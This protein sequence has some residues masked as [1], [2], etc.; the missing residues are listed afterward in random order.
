[1]P[2]A[3]WRVHP[4]TEDQLPDPFIE[5]LEGPGQSPAYRGVAYVV[6]EDLP[7]DS[8]GNRLPQLSFEVIRPSPDP[9]SM[10]QLVRAVN[11]IPAAGEFIY[12]TETVTRTGAAP[13]AWEEA[14]GPRA[15]VVAMARQSPRTRMGSR[16]CPILLPH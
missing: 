9:G 14:R 10:E 16:A 12:A 8:F 2:G 7:L 3:V 4:G 1:M 11:L 13:G 5:A 6:F 15:R